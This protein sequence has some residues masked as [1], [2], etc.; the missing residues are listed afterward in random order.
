MLSQTKLLHKRQRKED[1]RN[2]KRK[3]TRKFLNQLAGLG[4]AKRQQALFHARRTASIL[5]AIKGVDLIIK[6]WC[7]KISIELMGQVE[8]QKVLLK[9]AVRAKDDKAIQKAVQDFVPIND[10]LI[11]IVKKYDSPV[12]PSK[13]IVTP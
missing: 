13:D 2:L 12:Q 9:A 4:T 8:N 5:D 3:A 7:D 10:Q 6:R 11:E 1:K